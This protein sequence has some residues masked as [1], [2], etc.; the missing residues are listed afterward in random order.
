VTGRVF[1]EDVI[2]ENLDIGR[3]DQVQ[4]IFDRRVG[5]STPGRFRTRVITDGVVPSLHVDYKHTRIKQY[6]K[7][8]RA[9]RTETTLNDTSDF[10]IG[11]RIKNLPAL[12]K[13]G[14]QANR[15]L[16]DVQRISHDCA[17]GEQS[18]ERAQHPVQV[19]RQRA[20]GL[21]YGDRRVHALLHA[22][23]PFRLLPSGFSN[24]D[25][26]QHLAPLLGLHADDLR[27]GRMTYDLRRLRLHGFIERI[28]KSHRYRITTEGF[29]AALFYVRTYA[30][31][32][33]PGLA[34]LSPSTLPY[35]LRAAFNN[36]E[37]S[38]DAWCDQA[39]LA[40]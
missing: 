18:F 36:V 5:K 20:A 24:C 25:L 14:F 23:L 27:P 21:R 7:E 11:K 40:A 3:P 15:R 33:R 6:H 17:I 34:M 31:I 22:L 38:I 37:R 2:R 16:L 10:R 29:R 19:N 13:I 26:R 32:L 39:K 9:L 12:R 4:L 1:F 30:R 35:P 8:G 28:P